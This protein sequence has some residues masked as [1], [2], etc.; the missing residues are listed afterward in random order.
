MGARF[1]APSQTGP[2]GHPASCTIGTV[3]FP[4]VKSDRGVTLIPYPSLVPWSRKSR[5]IP[6]LPL[7]AVRPVQ[8]LSA[9]TTVHFNFT[10]TSIPPMDRTACTE[11]QCLYNGALCLYLYLYSPYGPY[12][13]YRPS[14]PVQGCSL[15]LPT[16]LFPLRTVRPVQSL[17]ACRTVHFALFLLLASSCLSVCP[18]VLMERLVYQWTYFHEL[19]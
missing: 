7:W 3:S 19:L 12:G 15:P 18:S 10:Y 8:S 4:G 6:L 1:Y 13:L 17:S 9:C 14:V 11:P 5:A 2:G 16:P